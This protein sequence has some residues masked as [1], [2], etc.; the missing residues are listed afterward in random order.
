MDGL[1]GQL[2]KP[3]TAYPQTNCRTNFDARIANRAAPLLIVV[4]DKKLENNYQI[5][6]LSAIQ[7]H[8]N[9]HKSSL[10]VRRER[11]VDNPVC[12]F[13]LHEN[14]FASSVF[15]SQLF[16]QRT[17]AEMQDDP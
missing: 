16:S 12:V 6:F 8:S 7:L 11:A 2:S 9:F 1:N 3:T 15:L 10:L 14:V 13:W 5:K 4:V 17:S